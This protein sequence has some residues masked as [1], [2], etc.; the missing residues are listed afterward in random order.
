MPSDELCKLHKNPSFI[1]ECNV[2]HYD[3]FITWAKKREQESEREREKKLTNKQ[4][5]LFPQ[6]QKVLTQTVSISI[7]FSSS[8]LREGMKKMGRGGKYIQV[9]ATQS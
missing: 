4:L 7:N 3:A 8:E 6:K 2:V 5:L 1:C 9:E